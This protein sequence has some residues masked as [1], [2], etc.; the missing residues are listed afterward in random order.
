MLGGILAASNSELFY[1]DDENLVSQTTY[2]FADRLLGVEAA[3]E[4]QK[5]NIRFHTPSAS[6][7]G[8][9]SASVNSSTRAGGYEHDRSGSSGPRND[10]SISFRSAADLAASIE[11]SQIY[12]DGG[13]LEEEEEDEEG[14]EQSGE[15]YDSGVA[16]E[17]GG[18]GASLHS[19][20]VTTGTGV[21]MGTG[22][23]RQ[24]YYQHSSPLLAG[25]AE[26]EEEEEDQDD[27]F[28]D[29]MEELEDST[30]I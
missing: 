5:N 4:Q 6:I 26:S 16:M 13:V 25:S 23:L 28:H 7:I 15:M 27:S 10:R 2:L 24:S 11:E 9:N 18:V 1:R 12:D 19:P 21:G 3:L 14:E 8:L 17:D 29:V 20:N 30:D 22:V